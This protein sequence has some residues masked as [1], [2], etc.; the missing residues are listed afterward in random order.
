MDQRIVCGNLLEIPGRFLFGEE[1]QTYFDMSCR[2]PADHGTDR[3]GDDGSNSRSPG[4]FDDLTFVG[5]GFHGVVWCCN[6]YAL[7]VPSLVTFSKTR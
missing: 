6:Q 4:G 1:F 3:T 5:P 7:F 2:K